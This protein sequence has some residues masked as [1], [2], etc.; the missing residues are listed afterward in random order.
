MINDNVQRDLNIALV[1]ELSLIFEKMG[2]IQRTCLRL[3]AP[4]G[5][6]TGIPPMLVGGHCIPVDP[7]FLAGRAINDSMPAHVAGMEFLL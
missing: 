3:P 4:N 6:S 7:C 1:N 5:T 2:L